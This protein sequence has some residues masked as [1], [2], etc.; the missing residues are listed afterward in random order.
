MPNNSNAA[1]FVVIAEF[2]VKPDCIAAFL[3]AARSDATQSLAKEPG[4]RQ[5]DIIQP[6]TPANTVIFYEVY[7]SRAAFD[8]HLA[9]AHV[10]EFRTAFPP[11]VIAEKPVRFATRRENLT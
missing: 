7:D 9:T 11:L 1:A 3:Q 5:F 10:D 6:E 2:E 8:A 4:C